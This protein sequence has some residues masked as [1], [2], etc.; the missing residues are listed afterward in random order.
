[1]GHGRRTDLK[2]NRSVGR[3]GDCFENACDDQQKPTDPPGYQRPGRLG[4]FVSVGALLH[5]A[6]QRGRQGQGARARSGMLDL[7]R[8]CS[9]PQQQRRRAQSRGVRLEV[10]GWSLPRA[11]LGACKLVLEA[12][13]LAMAAALA[14]SSSVGDDQS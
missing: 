7:D 12:K 9:F 10:A 3:F 6:A 4:S 11:D 14:I 8:Q 2:R 13:N 5:I 1:M